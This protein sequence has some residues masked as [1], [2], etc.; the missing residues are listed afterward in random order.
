MGKTVGEKHLIDK[1]NDYSSQEASHF[2]NQ[3]ELYI[4]GMDNVIEMIKSHLE[5]ADSQAVSKLKRKTEGLKE[6]KQNVAAVLIDVGSTI[7]YDVD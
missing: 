1:L 4:D 3:K 2:A 5:N 7:E 6:K